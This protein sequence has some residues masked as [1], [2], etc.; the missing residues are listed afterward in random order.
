MD[1]VMLAYLN[2]TGVR[3]KAWSPVSPDLA[4]YDGNQHSL[5]RYLGQPS[6]TASTGGGVT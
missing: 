5:L 1:V 3:G 6:H 4:L 2:E